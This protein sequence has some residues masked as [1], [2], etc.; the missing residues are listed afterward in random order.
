MINYR[1]AAPAVDLFTRDEHLVLSAWF[2]LEKECS[3][4]DIE[5]I[6]DRLNI[7]DVGFY[8]RIDVGVARLLLERIQ[9]GLPTTLIWTGST[10]DTYERGAYRKVELLPQY[11]FTINWADSGPGVCWPVSYQATYVPGF[12]RTV[13]TA[14]ADSADMFGACD[15][16]LGAFGPDRS[17][18]QGSREAIT[19]DWAKQRDGHEQE[20]WTHLFG[21]GLVD[22]VEAQAWADEVWPDGHQEDEE[23]DEPL[24]PFSPGSDATVA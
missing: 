3:D 20:P 8:R 12:D 13:V 4:Q 14:S 11:L 1:L 6:L 24:E 17:I 23:S 15:F 10:R 21:T 18:V 7:P 22:H 2:G 16:A 19:A 5:D 9:N